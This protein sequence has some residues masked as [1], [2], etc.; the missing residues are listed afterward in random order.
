M[1]NAA[2]AVKVFNLTD[3]STPTLKQRGLVSRGFQVGTQL[4]QPGASAQFDGATW[5]SLKGRYN[6]LLTLGALFVGAT[7]P[8]SYVQ[9][10]QRSVGNT[11]AP[12]PA[13]PSTPPP[14]PAPTPSKE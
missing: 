11:P 8:V 9:G 10:K 14:P 12:A 5:A 6:R 1:A 2:P 4:I 7:P 13:K 3:V